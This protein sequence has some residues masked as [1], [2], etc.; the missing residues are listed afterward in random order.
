MDGGSGFLCDSVGLHFVV[1]RNNVTVEVNYTHT[2]VVLFV[3]IHPNYQ[4]TGA[5][6]AVDWLK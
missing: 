4:I 1:P 6:Y 2:Y 5:T 3:R